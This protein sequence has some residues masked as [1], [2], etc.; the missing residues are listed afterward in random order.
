MTEAPAGIAVLTFV[1]VAGS[2]EAPSIRCTRFAIGWRS[3]E[4]RLCGRMSISTPITVPLPINSSSDAINSTEPP[5]A[6]PVSMMM[7]GLWPR[8]L[9]CRHHVRSSWM[10]GTPANSTGRSSSYL[11]P[12]AAR[13]RRSRI[14]PVAASAS[15]MARTCLCEGGR[16]RRTTHVT[17]SGLR[18]RR[19]SCIGDGRKATAGRKRFPLFPENA[20]EVAARPLSMGHVCDSGAA[21]TSANG[22]LPLSALNRL[23]GCAIRYSF[24]LQR[25]GYLSSLLGYL[26]ARRFDID[27][28]PR[29]EPGTHCHNRR[30][31]ER[32]GLGHSHEVYDPATPIY[33]K[34]EQG[35]LAVEFGL[36]LLFADRRHS[37][38]QLPGIPSRPAGCRPIDSGGPGYSINSTSAIISTF[39]GT[40]LLGPLDAG[41]D[42]LKRIVG[43]NEA[44]IRHSPMRFI[45]Q[46]R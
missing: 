28:S 30:T 41:D 38:H 3:I 4:S 37:A 29:L 39:Q 26:A 32:A 8:S 45:V 14:P 27:P 16:D 33:R 23:R 12:H 7:S 13:P 18:P 9:L 43:T 40:G 31:V 36:L 5:R 25:P 22:G 44:I 10:I 6:T 42:G 20:L 46:A 2:V 11:S 34:M 24:H 19:R 35:T 17:D 1:S 15:D 21:P